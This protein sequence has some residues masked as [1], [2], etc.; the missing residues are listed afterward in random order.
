M[1][2]DISRF[3]RSL[4]WREYFGNEPTI[5]QLAH[6]TLLAFML[7]KAISKEVFGWSKWRI[8]INPGDC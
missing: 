7:S 5:I 3:S 2:Y 6:G 1:N 8:L 4:R